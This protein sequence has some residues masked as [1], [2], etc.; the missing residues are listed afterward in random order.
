MLRYLC[1]DATP[2]S[3]ENIQDIIKAKNSMKRTPEIHTF[4]LDNKSIPPFDFDKEGGIKDQR[5]E[6][7]L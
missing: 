3:T 1:S 4:F 6:P 7:I 2:L 5:A